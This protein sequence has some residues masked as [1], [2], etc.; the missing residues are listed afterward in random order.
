MLRSRPRQRATSSR[1][2]TNLSQRERTSGA[3]V[4]RACQAPR[5][6]AGIAIRSCNVPNN[7]QRILRSVSEARSRARVKYV[8]AV[9]T[10][11]SRIPLMQGNKRDESKNESASPITDAKMFVSQ[12]RGAPTLRAAEDIILRVAAT[13]ICVWDLHSSKLDLEIRHGW[14]GSNWRCRRLG[15]SHVEYR[16]Y[17]PHSRGCDA[18]ENSH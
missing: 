15:N 14:A 17:C 12:R 7:I 5:G 16:F 10:A 13:A 3:D 18:G 8:F 9:A 6:E 11:C 2:L 1:T 4:H